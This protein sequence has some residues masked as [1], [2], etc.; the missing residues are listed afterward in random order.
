MT[1]LPS[2]AMDLMDM[3]RAGHLSPGLNTATVYHRDG[4]RYWS[5]LACDCEPDVYV[6]AEPGD[7][8]L[9]IVHSMGG[10]K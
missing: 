4:C 1:G 3:C 8:Q 5:G 7:K 2:Y 6:T 9:E 10:R